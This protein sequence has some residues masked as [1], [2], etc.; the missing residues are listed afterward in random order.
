MDTIFTCALSQWSPGLGDNHPMGWLTVVLYLLAAAA[1][2]KTALRGTF[3]A[4]TQDRE[5]LFWWFAATTLLLL[6][7]NKQ[8][9][10]QSLLTAVARCQAMIQGWYEDRRVVQVRFVWAVLGVGVLGIFALGFF[11]RA[12]FART[13][14][15][16]L[17]LGLV[18]GFVAIRAA[19]FHHV[20][21]LINARWF[22]L[23]LN[24]LLEMSGPLIVLLASVRAGRSR[25]A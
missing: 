20:D 23:R 11:L 9:D 10:L 3:P 21:T 6:A 16:V 19:S 5:R 14:L 15:A 17:G 7:F 24:W 12:T 25:V 2:A 22:G 1:C 13:G 18:C 8:L 4:Q